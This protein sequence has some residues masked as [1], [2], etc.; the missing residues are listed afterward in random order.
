MIYSLSASFRQK[1]DK[2][3][4]VGMSIRHESKLFAGW[5]GE[6]LLQHCRARTPVAHI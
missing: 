5:G 1:N 6:N 2:Q 3:R 4:E